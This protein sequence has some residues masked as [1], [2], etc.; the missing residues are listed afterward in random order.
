M[1]VPVRAELLGPGARARRAGRAL[2]PPHARAGGEQLAGAAAPLAGARGLARAPAAAARRARRAAAARAAE[3]ARPRARRAR[4]RRGRAAPGP[5]RRRPMPAPASGSTPCGASPSSPIPTGR[6]SAAMPGSRTATGHVLISA[7]A[8]RDAKL[9]RLAASATVAS[10]PRSAQAVERPRA[11]ALSK[12]QGRPAEIAVTRHVHAD[13][14]PER[15]ARPAPLSPRHL[16]RALATAIM[17]VRGHPPADPARRAALLERRAAG[18]LLLGAK[19]RSRRNRKRLSGSRRS[20]RPWSPPRSPAGAAQ[21]QLSGTPVQG[22]LV[23]GTAPAGNRFAERSTAA[24]CRSPPTAASCSA[25]I[26]TRG[27]ARGSSRARRRQRDRRDAARGRPPRLADPAYRHGPRL[28]DGPTPE[29]ARLRD[30]RAAPD[31]RRPRR[32]VRRA[33]AGR[34]ASSGRRTGGSAARSA[35]SASIAAAFPAAYH[36][37]ADIAAGA[38]ALVV[39]PA[40]GVVTLAPPPAFS[41]E[42]NLVILDHGMGLTSAFLHLS[43]ALVRPASGAPGRSDRPGRRDRPRDRAAPP[44]EPGLERRADRSRDGGG[45]ASSA[46]S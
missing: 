27:R 9:L 22:A 39:A 14:E 46:A 21:F 33:W 45:A 31:R 28:P 38:G 23:R 4:P 20:P 25:S 35:R 17:S 37:G 44:L 42:G 32:S 24:R 18:G 6:S 16:P 10:T 3:P 34:S 43:S 30:G 11:R 19:P 36:S 26:A 8:A 5:A 29:Y 41:L 1:A 2:R 7:A 13:V 15:P 40:D 12:G